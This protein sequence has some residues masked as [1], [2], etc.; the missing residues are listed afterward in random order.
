MNLVSS[1]PIV[2]KLHVS[3]YLEVKYINST[4]HIHYVNINMV[5]HFK[6]NNFIYMTANIYKYNHVSLTLMSFM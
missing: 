5:V 3:Y 2:N 6:N 4:I 1:S